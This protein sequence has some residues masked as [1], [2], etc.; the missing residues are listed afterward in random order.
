MS[1][2]ERPLRVCVAGITGWTGRAVPQ[3]VSAAPALVLVSGV[4]LVAA[5]SGWDFGQLWVALALAAFV[6][7]FLLG[8]VYL[9]R[10]ALALGKLADCVLS[11]RAGHVNRLEDQ[12]QVCKT[13]RY[14]VVSS[15]FPHFGEEDCLRGTRGSGTIFFGWCNLRCVFCQNWEISWEGEGREASADA[16]ADM[17]L[18]LQQ[19]GCHNVNLVSPSHVVAQIIAAVEIAARRGLSL[20]LVYN[21][22]GYDSLEGLA[23]LDGLLRGACGL[24]PGAS[25]T[26]VYVR[27][28]RLWDSGRISEAK[29]LFYRFQPFLVFGL[30]HLELFIGME[31]EILVRRGIFTSA[32]LRTP[33]PVF[34]DQ[35]QQQAEEWIDF[36]LKL[37]E[38]EK[39]YA[40]P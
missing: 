24:M 8:A 12:A 15:A 32:R 31:K 10:A 22:G 6:V 30:Q 35:Y 3:A 11:P 21:S 29:S 13:G 34:D 14:A 40:A 36:V 39:T 7:A 16:L 33:T 5:S 4:W 38:E 18:R 25:L 19:I 9:S 23:L 37:T 17:M 26:D 27:I 28:F 2:S 20:P 1:E